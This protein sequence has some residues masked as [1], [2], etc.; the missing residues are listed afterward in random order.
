MAEELRL[1]TEAV[2]SSLWLFPDAAEPAAAR[3]KRF[4]H[5]PP[6]TQMASFLGLNGDPQTQ[7]A[8]ELLFYR[9]HQ[10]RHQPQGYTSC[11]FLTS[12]SFYHC[13]CS[14]F[15]KYSKFWEDLKD[16]CLSYGGQQSS[17]CILISLNKCTKGKSKQEV[18][19]DH[20]IEKH[21]STGDGGGGG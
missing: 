17:S 5:S 11:P 15:Y 7:H 12:F 1:V 13:Q 4:L 16:T 20:I 9:K 18:V 8:T 14:H 10:S 3:R 6:T 21:P 19:D 2:S